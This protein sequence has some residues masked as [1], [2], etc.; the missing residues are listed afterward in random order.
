M[1]PL[2]VSTRTGFLKLFLGAALLAALFAFAHPRRLGAALAA[3]DGLLLALAL[4]AACGAVVVL[5][6]WRFQ[7]GFADWGLGFFSALRI[8]L[9]GQFV[10]SF[11]PG[12][13]GAEG[14]KIYAVRQ[15]GQGVA[16]PLV[17]LA[18]LRALGALA[19][20]AAA[21]VAW[22]VAPEK[23]QG[24]VDRIVHLKI[25]PM[26]WMAAAVAV[27]VLGGV[28]FFL[29]LRRL[30]AWGRE[31]LAEVRLLP[32]GKLLLLSLGVALLRGVSLSL[33]VRSFGE[34]AHFGDL[35]VVVALS[36]LASTLPVS[37][38]GL[39]VQEGVLAGCLALLGLPPPTA[40]A[41]SLL[42][43]GFL[44]LFAAFGGLVLAVRP[45]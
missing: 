32:L 5:E 2:P 6:A 45:R 27:A 3:A 39:G 41:I 25:P 13:V 12:T 30:A 23:S 1:K 9:A 11:T 31:A 17:R 8:T 7:A 34:K 42:N 15:P 37:P 26:A 16:R 36:V 43:R 14:Y 4:A 24:I 44:W 33:L 28:A 20:L 19:V 38:A 35:L 21:S 10:G 22:L 29:G 18:L 40:V